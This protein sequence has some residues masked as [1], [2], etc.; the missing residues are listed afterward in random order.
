LNR[1]PY[2]NKINYLSG[3]STPE[4]KMERFQDVGVAQVKKTKCNNSQQ[5]LGKKKKKLDGM[6]SKDVW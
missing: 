3:T 6:S 5:G 4:A 2:Y 1:P